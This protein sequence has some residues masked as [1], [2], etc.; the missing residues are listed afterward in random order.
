MQKISIVFFGTH[1]FAATILEGLLK[2]PDFSVDLV[3]T[4]PDKPIGRKQELQKSPVKLLAEKNNLKIEQPIKLTN[5]EFRIQNSKLIDLAVVAQYGLLIPKNILDLPKYGTLNVHTSLLPKY[6][7][8]SPIQSALIN[9]ETE[10]GVT[11]MKM[12]EGF[13]TGPILLQK[14]LKIEPEDTYTTLE[15]KLAKIAKLA[16]TEAVSG[17]VNGKITPKPQEDSLATECRQLSRNDGKIDWHKS[18]PEIYN[19]YRGLTPWPGVWTKL[20]N[21]RLKLLKI[22]LA[23]KK[24]KA[25]HILIE[26]KKLYIGCSNNSIEVLELQLEGKKPMT[27]NE[28][29]N[30]HKLINGQSMQ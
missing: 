11:I 17:Y 25:G 22:E 7:G 8:A 29:L 28:F 27:T 13:D 18:A 6:R 9:G 20:N 30:G 15:E 12:D 21:K 2:N 10:T 23:D 14:T 24:I 1:N 4:Q 5:A 19:L 26:D 3:I 16:L